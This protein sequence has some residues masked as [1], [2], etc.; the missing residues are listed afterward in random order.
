MSR[1]LLIPALVIGVLV[2]PRLAPLIPPRL[3]ARLRE[4]FDAAEF[5]QISER[6]TACRDPKDLL[7]SGHCGASPAWLGTLNQSGSVDVDAASTA[8]AWRCEYKNLSRT[9]AIGIAA[10]VYCIKR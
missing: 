3:L 2:W 9:T 7:V 6:I 10:T 8:A 1:R 5:V 4:L